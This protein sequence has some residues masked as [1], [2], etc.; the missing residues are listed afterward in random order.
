MGV[1]V[2]PINPENLLYR[3]AERLEFGS[4]TNAVATDGVRI[5]QRMDRDWMTPGR[6]PAGV[7][8]AA[9]IIAARMHNYRRTVREMVYVAKVAEVTLMKRLEEFKNTESSG[10]TV[11]EFRKIDLERFCDPPA[12]YEQNSRKKRIKRKRKL[13]NVDDDGDTDVESQRATSAAPSAT[14]VQ[15]QTL[16][17]TQRQTQI[18]SQNMPPPPIPV[19]PTL[20]TSQPPTKKKRGRPPKTKPSTAQGRPPASPPPSQETPIEPDITTAMSD[21]SSL[22]HA[23][24]LT[25]VL[26]TNAASAT[27]P[28]TQ[29]DPAHPPREPIPLTEHISDSEFG[30]DLEVLECLLTPTEVEIKTRIWTHENREW[31]RAQHAKELKQKLAE[32]NGT[33][34][35]VKRRT[36]RRTRMGDMASYRRESEQDGEVGEVGEGEGDED[37]MPAR[38]AAEAT[39]KMMK[40]RAYSKKINYETLKKLYEPSSKDSSASGSRRQSMSAASGAAASPGAGNI[41]A[42]PKPTDAVEVTTPSGTTRV[43]HAE[44]ATPAGSNREDDAGRASSVAMD[45]IQAIA[46]EEEEERSMMDPGEPIQ[47]PD[48][49]NEDDEDDDPDDYFNEEE[50]L[51][52]VDEDDELEDIEDILRKAREKGEGDLEEAGYGDDYE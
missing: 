13:V 33:V 51:A 27:P 11:E 37:S 21:P 22:T 7:C 6:R 12:F 2:K 26:D 40:K 49:L 43:E 32:D 16:T 14:D 5:L 47:I 31:I 41:F 44:V 18:D 36:R 30:L 38:S 50:D 19:D 25:Q 48:P 29:Q 23:S 17:H 39:M 20:T 46:Q 35:R 9:L 10:L 24:A 52:E 28:P 34:P 15:L 3:F 4:D 1:E 8:G 45:D 42:S